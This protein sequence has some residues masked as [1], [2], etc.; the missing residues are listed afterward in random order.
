MSYANVYCTVYDDDA[1]MN[2]SRT[3]FRHI[4]YKHFDIPRYKCK[5]E[6]GMLHGNAHTHTHLT[7]TGHTSRMHLSA[8]I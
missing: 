5:T 4:M 1:R 8:N 7:Q 6:A 3:R 2:F